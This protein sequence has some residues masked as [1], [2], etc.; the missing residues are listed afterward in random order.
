MKRVDKEIKNL[1][2]ISKWALS[3]KTKRQLKSV[4]NFM[5]NHMNN[6]KPFRRYE[7]EESH[8]V[9]YHAGAVDGIIIILKKSKF[10]DDSK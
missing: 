7:M 3:C 5:S 9:I 2:T 4:E 1:I 6:M 10:K 8:R